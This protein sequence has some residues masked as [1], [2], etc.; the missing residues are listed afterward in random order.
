[1]KN[2][3]IAA[4]ILGNVIFSGIAYAGSPAADV[5]PTSIIAQSPLY[6]MVKIGSGKACNADN[7]VS[8]T[9]AGCTT[10]SINY[11]GSI[12]AVE[13]TLTVATPINVGSNE[14]LTNEFSDTGKPATKIDFDFSTALTKKFIIKLFPNDNLTDKGKLLVKLGASSEEISFAEMYNTGYFNFS[15]LDE[16]SIKLIPLNSLD[17]SVRNQ[18]FKNKLAVA[19]RLEKMAEW[20]AGKMQKG[21]VNPELYNAYAELADAAWYK[22]YSD[23]EVNYFNWRFNRLKKNFD[24]KDF[25][26]AFFYGGLNVLMKR[27]K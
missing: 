23:E 21:E 20:A 22:N 13:G 16:R 12:E 25:K 24:T 10:K 8:E 14:V 5:K 3:L 26:P 19:P 18:Q 9:D 1:M 6:L 11:K 2:R 15:Q 27:Y 7:A 4:L 17:L